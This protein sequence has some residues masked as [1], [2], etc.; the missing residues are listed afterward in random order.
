MEKT[1]KYRQKVL[2]EMNWKM[3]LMIKKAHDIVRKSMNTQNVCN[4]GIGFEEES[5]YFS[6]K[7]T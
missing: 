3:F 5:D 6:N 2:K 1:I 4:K 7:Q